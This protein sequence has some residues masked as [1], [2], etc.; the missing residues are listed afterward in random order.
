MRLTLAIFL[1][2]VSATVHGQAGNDPEHVIREIV[3]TGFIDG[4]SQKVIGPL[5][6]SGAV[7]LTRVL[8]G[9]DLTPKAI[10]DALEV[11]TESF[12]DPRLIQA[13]SDKEPRTA[14]LV[15]K[16]LDL[17]TDNVGL[18]RH[19]ANTRKYVQDRYAAA[20]QATR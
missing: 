2:V 3:D 4:H 6:D 19:V 1:I 20:L 14:M 11:I 15:L 7:F 10:D 5:G 16:Y 12:A 18:K 8:G 13:A 9:R 17:S